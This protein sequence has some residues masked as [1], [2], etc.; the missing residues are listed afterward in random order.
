MLLLLQS[1]G[2]IF[3]ALFF[4]IKLGGFARD[5]HSRL[6]GPLVLYEENEVVQIQFQ[7]PC[8]QHFIFFLIYEWAQYA[9]VLHHTRLE[10]LASEKH[11][12]LLCPLLSY[13][14]NKKLK[15]QSQGRYSQHF[16]FFLHSSHSLV[17]WA[18]CVNYEE[19]EVL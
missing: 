7:G 6:L 4:Y 11:S 1:P 16:I 12:S 18:K 2:T 19:S 14:E 5:E 9:R 15:I 10:R 3:S 13:E 8:S 17:Y